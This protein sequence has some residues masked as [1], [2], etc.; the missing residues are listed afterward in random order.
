MKKII[1]DFWLYMDTC[2]PKGINKEK[3]LD[4]KYGVNQSIDEL[5]KRNPIIDKQLLFKVALRDYLRKSDQEILKEMG[6]YYGQS[7]RDE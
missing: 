2:F 5:L 3:Y 4:L 6:E 1:Q 7:R